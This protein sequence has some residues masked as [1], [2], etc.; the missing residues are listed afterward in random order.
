MP[1]ALFIRIPISRWSLTPTTQINEH[2]GSKVFTAEKCNECLLSLKCVFL[3]NILQDFY[4]WQL[5]VLSLRLPHDADEMLIAAVFSAM[6]P[7]LAFP[8]PD[9]ARS[10]VQSGHQ[11]DVKNG[12][13]G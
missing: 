2:P 3:R 4:A 12:V 9:I 6:T 10:P 11:I 1:N 8:L 13:L 5:L 7:S